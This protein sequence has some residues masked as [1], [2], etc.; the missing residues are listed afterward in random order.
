MIKNAIMILILSA[1]TL[2]GLGLY[3]IID[4][5]IKLWKNKY[6]PYFGLLR[7]I[8]GSFAEALGLVLWVIICQ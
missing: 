6:N 2:C 5:F 3:L 8:F 1:I 4:T 7:I